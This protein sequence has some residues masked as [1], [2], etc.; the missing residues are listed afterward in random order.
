M[1]AAFMTL[2]RRC[3]RRS[4]RSVAS[5]PR[6]AGVTGASFE[7]LVD[8]S[9]GQALPLPPELVSRYGGPFRMRSPCLY[10]N[11]VESMDGVVALG[12]E[13][14]NSGSL[15]SGRNDSDRF[16]LG[17]LRACADAVL[18]GAGTLRATPNHRWVAEHVYPDAAA[19]FRQL[20]TSLG[21]PVEPRL[22]VVTS[23]GDLPLAHP[24]LV[25]A[26]VLTTDAGSDR[27]RAVAPKG[28]DIRS[29]GSGPTIS[30][31]SLVD[32][33]RAEDHGAVLTEGGPRL[34]AELLRAELVDE[35]FLTLSPMLLG[36]SAAEPR[37]AL[38]EGAAFS[39]ADA[40]RLE[41]V[42]ARRD[43]DFMFVR[44]S[45]GRVATTTRQDSEA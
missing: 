15:I 37:V 36:R 16:L 23:R 11:F 42:S 39:A 26:V 17:L 38:V 34:V 28:L 22:F 4:P 24:G 20:R 41:L 10:A 3:G 25:N 29:L 12:P 27:L 2:N 8:D 31:R 21:M 9:S 43:G 35:L 45:V 7:V 5:T 19:A 30:T 33:V 18:V 14:P 13:H 40:P 44:Y 32:A 1:P 6:S